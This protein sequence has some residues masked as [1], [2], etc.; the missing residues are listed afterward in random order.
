ML[1]LLAGVRRKHARPPVQKEAVLAEDILAMIATLSFGLRD[2][3]ILLI[4]YAADVR[5]SE[6][7]S[8]DINRDDTEDGK[9]WIAIE[10][11]VKS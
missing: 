2:S 1:L 8:L 10:N 5:R 7:V 3:A 11:K 4:G 9:G 6:I